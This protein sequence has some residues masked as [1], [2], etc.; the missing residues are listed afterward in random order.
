MFSA[1]QRARTDLGARFG[2]R[3]GP[4]SMAV[5]V[6]VS[7]LWSWKVFCQTPQ[8]DPASPPP[9]SPPVKLTAEQKVELQRAAQ[10]NEEVVRLLNAGGSREALPLAEQ[11]LAIRK[12]VLGEQDPEYAV[13]LNNLATLYTRMGEHAKA[14]PRPPATRRL[15]PR[16]PRRSR[17]LAARPH[18]GQTAQG[19][20]TGP[21]WG[22]GA[23]TP[24]LPSPATPPRL[25]CRR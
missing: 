3:V 1:R 10:M 8:T 4:L 6:M 19:P 20:A 13:S 12:K 17:R 21:R 18:L 5:I 24:P 25:P 11:A 22:L 14:E 9:A 7:M 15:S 23:Y 16:R 2:K